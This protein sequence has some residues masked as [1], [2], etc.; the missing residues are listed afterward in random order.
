MRFKHLIS[1]M[2]LAFIASPALAVTDTLYIQKRITDTLY[3]VSP[4]DTVYI[5]ESVIH[6]PQNQE[7]AVPEAEQKNEFIT[8]YSTDTIAPA[9]KFYIG[10]PT[11]FSVIS[12]FFGAPMIDFSW[13]IENTH[14]GSLLFNISTI[15]LFYD[16]QI[17]RETKTWKGVRS[18]ITPEIGYRQYLLTVT[19]TNE[20][21]HKH[22]VKHRNTPLNSYS[23][24]VQTLG[25]PMMKLAY[26]KKY[27]GDD[28]MKGSFDPGVTISG[29]AG[30]VSNISNFLWDFG[31]TFGYEYWGKNARQFLDFSTYDDVNY[32]IIK[33]TS[34]KG[35]FVASQMQMG[36]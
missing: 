7:Q 19:T 31:I 30:F 12:I 24:S 11:G 29:T 21:P 9:K 8:E 17:L 34:G 28:S 10:L 13:E 33:G 2:I 18:I 27:K 1:I 22:P 36:F 35:F 5:Q 26:D 4:P 15:L 16:F 32:Q 6:Q 20:N 23:I 14:R 3:V 25:G